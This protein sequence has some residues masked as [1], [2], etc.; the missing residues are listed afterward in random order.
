MIALVVGCSCLRWIW[1]KK[2]F[3]AWIQMKAYLH[4]LRIR[5]QHVLIDI[6]YLFNIS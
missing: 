4:I 2:T 5:I 3:F 6:L 1:K